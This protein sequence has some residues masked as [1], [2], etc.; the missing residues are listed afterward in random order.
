VVVGRAV[1][2]DGL[3]VEQ[4]PSTVS[5]RRCSGQRQPGDRCGP[6]GRGVE[7]ED[8]A[9]RGRLARPVRAEEA[10]DDAGPDGEVEVA[11]GG[12]FAIALREFLD[13]D[14]VVIVRRTQASCRPPP[15]GC[16]RTPHGVPGRRTADVHPYSLRG[17]REASDGLTTEH[18]RVRT[19]APCT[20]PPST[21]AR[22]RTRYGGR[23]AGPPASRPS[24]RPLYR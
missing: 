2:V 5:G 9:H 23:A 1:R 12:V 6:L 24:A 11:H 19:M 20:T 14:H 4:A 22:R 18:V 17:R 16:A 15:G 8:H 21:P 3:G 13:V 7:T 10:G